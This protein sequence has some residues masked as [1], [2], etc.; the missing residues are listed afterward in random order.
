MR[1]LARSSINGYLSTVHVHLTI[2][3][4]VKPRPRKQ[5]VTRG[6]IRRHRE[7]VVGCQRATPFDGL[8]DSESFP[9]VV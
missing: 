5:G 3:N 6:G 7:S 9:R 2:P 8:D 4:L 1:S